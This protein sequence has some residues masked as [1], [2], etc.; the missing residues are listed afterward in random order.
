[1]HAVHVLHLFERQP[2][3][4]QGQRA[5]PTLEAVQ[6][7]AGPKQ[8]WSQQGGLEGCAEG[9]QGSC[10]SPRG[11]HCWQ[12]KSCLED[13]LR[14]ICRQLCNYTISDTVGHWGRPGD[15]RRD[16]TYVSIGHEI[17]VDTGFMLISSQY[18]G[19]GEAEGGGR[20]RG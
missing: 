18:I 10:F 2:C 11:Q 19:E 13:M 15:E 17:I 5:V 14:F 12:S 4:R 6:R 20:R 16:C 1:M 3:C 7:L 9:P 8:G